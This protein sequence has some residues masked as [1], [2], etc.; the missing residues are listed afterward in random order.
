MTAY[1][2]DVHTEKTLE[3]LAGRVARKDFTMPFSYSSSFMP[4]VKTITQTTPGSGDTFTIA[5][6]PRKCVYLFGMLS[7]ADLTN[8]A[9]V[10]ITDGVT[11]Y[12]L[13]D[14]SSFD[15]AAGVGQSM[16]D[17]EVI[18]TAGTGGTTFTLSILFVLAG[19]DDFVALAAEELS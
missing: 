3:A 2:T 5:Q 6:L 1:S 8:V 13:Y 12:Q 16:D 19:E 15:F 17:Y 9:G 7:S 11:P 4:F 18:V 10:S 14:G